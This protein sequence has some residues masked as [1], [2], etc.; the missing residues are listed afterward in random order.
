MA[1]RF[2]SDKCP[3]C[4]SLK[5]EFRRA[6]RDAKS[7]AVRFGA[8]N[9]RAFPG[10]AER[11]GVTSQ[12]WI[13]AIYAGRRL[14]DLASL[15]GAESMVRFAREQH[16]KAGGGVDVVSACQFWSSSPLW[17]KDLP[18]WPAEDVRVLLV[19]GGAGPFKLPGGAGQAER[20]LA[21]PPGSQHLAGALV[22][23]AAAASGS[24]S[25]PWRR[26]TPSR[27]ARLAGRRDLSASRGGC[28]CLERSVS[29]L[30]VPRRGS[31]RGVSM[32]YRALAAKGLGQAEAALPVPHLPEAPAGAA[33]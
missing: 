27:P 8:V 5:P 26:S 25:T 17:A 22:S 24:F 28:G 6:S 29:I 10:L 18:K 13:V 11:F 4:R 14:E 33:V 16:R 31:W 23:R 7:L 2:Y 32:V 21:R 12:P 30:G 9:A 1:A 3:F 20:H 19:L 15:A